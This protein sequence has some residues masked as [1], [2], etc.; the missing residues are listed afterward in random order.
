MTTR[1]LVERLRARERAAIRK[2]HI[3]SALVFQAAADEI[4]R[5][6]KLEPKPRDPKADCPHCGKPWDTRSCAMGGCPLGADL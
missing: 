5:L 1:D 4:E 3:H 6:R 2:G